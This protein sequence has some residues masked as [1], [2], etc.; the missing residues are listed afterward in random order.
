MKMSEVLI[1][2]QQTR[3]QIIGNLI[4][5]EAKTIA[6]IEAYCAMGALACEKGLFKENYTKET[7]YHWLQNPTY[8]DII[9]AYDVEPRMDLV[10]CGTCSENEGEDDEYTD[11]E[12]GFD[13]ISDYI[14]HLND[15]HSMTF[16]DIGKELEDLGY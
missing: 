7:N 9:R 5:A 2:S 8:T 16:E 11:D 10:Q 3:K 6:E 12:H 15:E 13:C 1:K 4:N 14:I